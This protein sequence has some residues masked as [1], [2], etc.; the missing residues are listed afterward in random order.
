[1]SKRIILNLVINYKEVMSRFK[2]KSISDFY[3]YIDA[4]VLEH[5][6]A[7]NLKINIDDASDKDKYQIQLILD[8]KIFMNIKRRTLTE[9]SF[10]AYKTF[11]YS[12]I[13]PYFK[14]Y[15]LKDVRIQDI[16]NF[17]QYLQ[18]NK[19]SERRIKNVLA[20]LNQIIKYFQNEGYID[21]TCVFEVKRIADIPKRQIQIL[22]PEQLAR[23]SKF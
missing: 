15:L 3:K 23:F 18:E 8:C 19:V 7:I 21:K 1:M 22:T 9:M 4:N 2:I 11:V 6:D 20:L 14:K 12:K 13:I 16:Q 10:Q 17:R 5:S